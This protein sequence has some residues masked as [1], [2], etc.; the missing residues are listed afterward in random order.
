MRLIPLACL[1][2][3]QHLTAP[4]IRQTPPPIAKVG[5][6]CQAIFDLVNEAAHSKWSAPKQSKQ[7]CWSRTTEANVQAA[8]VCLLLATVLTGGG[9]DTFGKEWQ[10]LE[11]QEVTANNLDPREWRLTA[12][13][14]LTARCLD[15]WKSLSPAAQADI[16]R[17]GFSFSVRLP[18]RDFSFESIP[19]SLRAKSPVTQAPLWM[20]LLANQRRVHLTACEE[21]A[22]QQVP[23]VPQ[24]TNHMIGF[25]ALMVVLLLVIG[26]LAIIADRQ[27][28]DQT[29]ELW[30]EYHT[31]SPDSPIKSPST[32]MSNAL[33]KSNSMDRR[34]KKP[35]KRN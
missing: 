19:P 24:P 12:S 23:H 14:A 29:S 21:A 18:S 2:A 34:R 3:G 33:K 9:A 11:R 26:L 20:S 16:R 15:G 35:K 22:I 1:V 32:P 28:S 17:S 31:K 8:D 27:Q 13:V 25:K 10:T 30:N 4:A 7:T 5:A 6:E